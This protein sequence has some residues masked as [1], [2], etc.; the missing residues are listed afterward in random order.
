MIDRSEA[1]RRY[2][3]SQTPMGVLQIKNNRNGKIFIASSVNV[4]ALINR[5]KLQLE[6]GSHPNKRLQAEWN[7]YGESAFDFQT[8]DELKFEKG[9]KGDPA[10]ELKVLEELWLDKLKPYGERGYH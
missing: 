3:E 2:K 7:E 1:K 9:E 5:Y 6:M 8:I 10:A 4:P